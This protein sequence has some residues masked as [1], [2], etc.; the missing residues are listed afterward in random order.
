MPAEVFRH[1]GEA[2]PAA[3][4]QA[5]EAVLSAVDQADAELSVMLCDDETITELNRAWR[6]K[7]EATD[8]LSFPQGEGPPGAPVLLGDVVISL[9]TCARQAA[10]RGHAEEVEQQVLLV[11]GVLHLLGYEH[12][13]PADRA[14]MQA[15]ESRL[16]SVLGL[17]A[18]SLIERA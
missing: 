1:E 12:D 4:Q 13:E 9:E 3:L 18:I 14:R 15:E 17:D 7:P 10:A 5:A 6:G 16:L 11:H 8:V 2:G